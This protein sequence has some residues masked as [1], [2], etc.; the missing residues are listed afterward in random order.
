MAYTHHDRLPALDAA[1]L[2]LEDANISMAVGVVA[3]FEAAPVR[4]AE[5]A[6][7]IERIRAFMEATL[8]YTPRFRQRL[9]DWFFHQL[10]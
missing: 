5:G 4:T 9:V 6:L 1:F 2:A 8:Q 10:R 7:D 3:L